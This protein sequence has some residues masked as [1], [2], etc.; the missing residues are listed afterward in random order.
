MRFIRRYIVTEGDINM[1]LIY[2]LI[3]SIITISAIV[4]GIIC[5]VIL[6]RAISEEVL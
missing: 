4:F 1:E 6:G 3:L 2:M 5:G